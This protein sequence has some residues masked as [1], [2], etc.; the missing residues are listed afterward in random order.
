MN[1]KISI[2]LSALVQ[3]GRRRIKILL[4]GRSDAREVYESMPFGIDGVPAQNYR[5]IYAETEEKGRNIVIGYINVN[6][7]STLNSGENH[8]YSTSDDGSKVSAFIKLLNDDTIEILGNGDF[9]VRYAGLETAFNQ[10]KQE[11]DNLVNLFNAHIHTT[12]ATVGSSPTPGVI[13]APTTS[14]SASTADITVARIS[15]I[16][17]AS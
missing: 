4:N 11:H 16:K 6:Q 5:A 17:T 13:S 12:T 1:I 10:L 7:L 14:G 3:E 9:L 15:E 2:F 8:I